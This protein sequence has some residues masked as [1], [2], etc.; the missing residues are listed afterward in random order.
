MPDTGGSHDPAYKVEKPPFELK[1]AYAGHCGRNGNRICRIFSRLFDLDGANES[2]PFVG[3]LKE[4]LV[5]GRQI[6][7]DPRGLKRKQGEKLTC[8]SGNQVSFGIVQL[9]ARRSSD[10]ISQDVRFRIDARIN[11]Y[12]RHAV[13]AP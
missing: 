5:D 1:A 8:T 7:Q 13:P 6:V 2:C 3:V 12:L 9:L 11:E 4:V 10:R